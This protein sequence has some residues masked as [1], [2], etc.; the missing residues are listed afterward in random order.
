MCPGLLTKGWLADTFYRDPGGDE[1]RAP[2]DARHRYNIKE[3]ALSSQSPQG[4]GNSRAL[5]LKGIAKV[6]CMAVLLEC[7]AR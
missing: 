4:D 2:Q 3:S 5:I 1:C 6:Q 7:M